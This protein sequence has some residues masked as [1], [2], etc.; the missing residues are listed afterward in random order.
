MIDAVSISVRPPTIAEQVFILAGRLGE[1][2][3]EVGQ[4]RA[5]CKA[6]KVKAA[7]ATPQG[8]IDSLRKTAG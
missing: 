1:L 5:Q 2:E 8:R 6:L 3:H 4:L 7:K